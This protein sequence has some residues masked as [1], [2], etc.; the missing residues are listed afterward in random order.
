MIAR[1][2]HQFSVWCILCLDNLPTWTFV[3]SIRYS[4]QILYLALCCSEGKVSRTVTV[5]GKT[6]SITGMG[7]HDH[8][9]G[10]INFH[11]YWNHWIWARQ[12]YDDCSLLLF[13]FFTN[14]EYGT[15]RFPII[16]IQDNNGKFIFESHNNVECKVEKQYTDKASGKQYPSIL[17]YT[18]KQDDTFV[19]TRYLKMNIF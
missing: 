2:V 10:S 17:D 7:Y 4:R 8:Q 18:F 12:S 6:K 3:F 19:D 13:D 5:E 11:K 14:E 9:W 15:K 16:F 1:S